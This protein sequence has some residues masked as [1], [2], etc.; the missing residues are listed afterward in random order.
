M[1]ACSNTVWGLCGQSYMFFSFCF[2]S[3]TQPFREEIREKKYVLSAGPECYYRS[4]MKSA[5]LV[6]SIGYKPR[7]RESE[8]SEVNGREKERTG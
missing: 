1:Y 2:E 3:R 6:F 4:R 8:W 7:E 5:K